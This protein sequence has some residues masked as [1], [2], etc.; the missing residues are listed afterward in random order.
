MFYSP[1]PRR[2]VTVKTTM[3]IAVVVRTMTA[4]DGTLKRHDRY[5]PITPLIMPISAATIIMC[6]HSLDEQLR[7]RRRGDEHRQH[8]GDADGLQAGDN[9]HGDQH[10]QQQAQRF[11]GQAQRAHQRRVEALGEQ[12]L[13]EQDDRADDDDAGDRP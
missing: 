4:P 9:R 6:V 10:Q 5:S 2:R 12:L 8:E 1:N 13:V 3:K 7:R 11:A